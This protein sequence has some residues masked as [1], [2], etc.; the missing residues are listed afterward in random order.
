VPG[1][2]ATV[3]RFVGDK[4][5]EL[6]NHLGNVLSVITD[7]SILSGNIFYPDVLTYSDYYPFGMQVPTRHGNTN[8]YRYGFQGQEMD[9]ELKGE[10]NSLNYTFRM[11]DP[12]IG[13]F[14]ARDPLSRDYPWNSPYA[15]S[16]N[17]PINFVDLEG[18][19]KSP[20][21][22][23]MSQVILKAASLG[24]ATGRDLLIFTIGCGESIMNANSIGLF[25]AYNGYTGNQTI[26]KFASIRDQRMYTAGRITGDVAAMFQGGNQVNFGGGLALTTGG[27]T[28]GAGAIA[29]GAVALHGAG[30]G[31]TAELDLLKR[32]ARFLS[33][34]N[35]LND[36]GSSEGNSSDDKG[37]YENPGHHD[38]HPK[39]KNENN[40][41]PNKSVL[42][43]NHE[44][45]WEKSVANLKKADTKWRK[46]GT[47]NK[48][49]Y[50]RFQDDGNGNW[51]WNGSTN[52]KNKIWAR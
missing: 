43:E 8:E 44:N 39:Q 2:P 1:T 23:Q 52:G 37:N 9:N 25:D 19:E 24:K 17:D 12:R 46:E 48:A 7:R 26:N 11:H 22:A 4:Q 36:K 15:F 14:F 10:G 18:Q 28:F 35:N 38:A 16:E 40:Y 21:A 30:V 49:T 27:E 45:L 50:H 3:Y 13:R 51:H 6:S 31:I 47:G 5:Y 41:N 34:S 29:G 20:T 42:P 33:M 32:G